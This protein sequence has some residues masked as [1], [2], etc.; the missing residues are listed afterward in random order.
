MASLSWFT[1]FAC[2]LIHTQTFVGNWW[3]GFAT[4]GYWPIFWSTF[5]GLLYLSYPVFG[6]LSEVLQWN[7]KTIL[8]SFIL[9][10]VSS[11]VMLITSTSWII[12]VVYSLW[13][14]ID[15]IILFILLLFLVTGII[16]VGMFEANAIQFGMDQMFEASSKQLSSFIRWYFWCAHIG[17]TLMIYLVIGVCL[18]GFNCNVNNIHF[19]TIFDNLIVFFCWIAILSACIQLPVSIIGIIACVY[20]KK[21]FPI[22]QAS[23]KPLRLIYSVLKYSYNHKQPE[24]RSALTYW[25]SD[26]PSR[27]DLGK[28]KYGGPFTYEQVESVKTVFRLLL[29]M[30]SLFGFHLSGDGYSV[31]TYIMNTAGCQ[32]ANVFLGFIGNPQHIGFLIVFLCIP[33]FEIFKLW[34]KRYYAISLESKIWIILFICLVNEA[35]Q[36]LYSIILQSKIY[37]CPKLEVVFH[38]SSILKCLVSNVNIASQNSTCQPFCSSPPVNDTVIYLSVIIMILHGLAYVLVFSSVLE[39]IC[40]QS[41]NETKGL[42]IG[43][44]YSML[45][46]KSF[47]INIIDTQVPMD[48]TDF[49]IYHGTKGVAIFI[50]LAAFSIVC[51]KYRY[52]ERNEIVNEQAMIEEQYERELLM[53]SNSLSYSSV[54]SVD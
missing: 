25:E 28:H 16:S 35:L 41:P 9:M 20:Y 4:Y 45:S 22:E 48:T 17:A 21:K 44:W 39:F 46:I 12:G 13:P 53:N 29:L 52:R 50:S 5:Q 34:K 10:A 40:A 1:L 54:L 23:R 32:T 26:I 3:M 19:N 24:R 42:L 33:L 43:L 36:S 6:L 2:V 18:Y 31:S 14:Q 11:I 49:N 51:K 37:Y 8:V 27:I 7:F 47:F 38:V 15:N 30:L